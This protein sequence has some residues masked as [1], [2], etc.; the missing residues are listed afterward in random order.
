MH[1][2]ILL[3]HLGSFKYRLDNRIT[4]KKLFTLTKQLQ[5]IMVEKI[6]V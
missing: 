2:I 6:W 5:E 1:I 4:K 3:L